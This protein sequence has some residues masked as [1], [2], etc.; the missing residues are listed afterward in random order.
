MASDAPEPPVLAPMPEP[1][2]VVLLEVVSP[3]LFAG[4][5]PQPTAASMPSVKAIARASFLDTV[6]VPFW[7]QLPTLAPTQT[8]GRN[9]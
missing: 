8:K 3:V 5:L 9:P 2:N 6:A 7:L 4:V 1:P